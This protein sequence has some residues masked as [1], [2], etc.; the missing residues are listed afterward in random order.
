VWYAV[1][2]E[3]LLLL[4]RPDAVVLV[5]EV[6]ET[7]LGL[8]EGGIGA[9]LQVAQIG[10]DPLLKLLRV[11]HRPPKRLESERKTSYNIGTGDVKEVV[12]ATFVSYCPLPST[13]RPRTITRKKRIRRLEEESAECTG[14]ES[15][16]Q[17]L[18]LKS[19]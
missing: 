13:T 8:F 15:S 1:P 7:T 10:K 12:P 3:D 4:L 5:E 9:R 2:V 11:L 6:Q 16:R 18:K 19:I 17:E 14:L